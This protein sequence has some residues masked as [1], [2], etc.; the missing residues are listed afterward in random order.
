MKAVIYPFSPQEPSTQFMEDFPQLRWTKV[1]SPE[2]VAASIGDAAI[3]VTSNRVCTPAVGAALRQG[4]ALRWVHFTSAGIERGI[5]MGLPDGVTVTNS[6][7]VK[8]TMVAEHAVALLLALVR[9][10]PESRAGREARQWR[11]EEISRRMR[12]LEGATVCIVGLG[13]IGRD[14]A[15]KLRAFDAHV[16]AVSRVGSAGGDI[17]AA[18]PRDRIREAL[19][20]ADAVVITTSGDE[21]SRH[22]IGAAELAAC[23]PTAF[24][25]NVAR[26]NIIAEAAL[27][28]ALEAGHVAGAGLDVAEA[29]PPAPDSPLWDLPN[30]ILTPHVA[31]Q[32]SSGYPQHK[33]LFAENLARFQAGQPLLNRCLAPEK[34]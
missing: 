2:E 24:I 13:N 9:R 14:V 22:L 12:T 3:Y 34:T 11:R 29:E 1:S 30:V 16:I 8:T 26:G 18:Y 6:T 33:K 31:G 19:A 5:A 20:R 4:R 7:G 17:E 28:E 27:V 10:M 21:T 32:G 23:K 15:R 25:V